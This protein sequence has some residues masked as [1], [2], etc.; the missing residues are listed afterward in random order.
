MKVLLVDDDFL[1]IEGLQTMIDWKALDADIVGTAENGEEALRLAIANKPDVII[2]DISMPVMDGLE[3]T[4]KVKEVLDN[5]HIFLI[6]GHDDFEY[7]RKAIQFGVTNYILKPVN[8]QTIHNLTEELQKIAQTQDIKKEHYLSLWDK[9]QKEIILNALK[10]GDTQFFDRLFE[11]ANLE[12][13]QAPDST[14]TKCLKLLNTLYAYFEE[15]NIG[16]ESVEHSRKNSFEEVFALSSRQ[17][18]L[19]FVFQ[20]YYD[21]LENI[22]KQKKAN[23]TSIAI[24]AKKMVDEGFTGVSLNISSLADQLDCTPAYLSTVFRQTVGVNLSVYITTLRIDYAKKLLSDMNY[25]ISDVAQVVGYADSHYFAKL[26]KKK[27]GFTPSEFR[28]VS[29]QSNC[30]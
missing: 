24:K 20:K 25:S 1:V 26:F 18:K 4:K 13:D 21:V 10:S 3:L 12:T 29:I 15:I 14:L 27:T 5:V 11:K 8:R 17:D 6:S 16:Q 22:D 9:E 7:A 30:D 23:S 2:T 28:N 19:N